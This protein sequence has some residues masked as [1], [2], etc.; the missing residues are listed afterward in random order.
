MRGAAAGSGLRGARRGGS[1]MRASP[2]RFITVAGPDDTTEVLTR[3]ATALLSSG[4]VS[5]KV[6]VPPDAAFVEVVDVAVAIESGV[7]TTP[8]SAP[9]AIVLELIVPVPIVPVVGVLVVGAVPVVGNPAPVELPLL[10]ELGALDG[11]SAP[12]VA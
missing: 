2:G 1:T 5:P 11:T 6:R 7:L 12:P 4:D 9:A 10:I 3:G 8:L